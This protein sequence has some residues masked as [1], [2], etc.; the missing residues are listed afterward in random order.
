MRKP[1]AKVISLSEYKRRMNP[2]QFARI[3]LWLAERASEVCKSTALLLVLTH[4]LYR[5]VG[6]EGSGRSR[7]PNGWLE[8][9]GVSRWTKNRV[10]RD[11]EAGGLITVDRS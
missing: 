10:L 1:Q 7:L 9:R 3:P 8:E 4:M 2:D 11:L 6:G 5:V